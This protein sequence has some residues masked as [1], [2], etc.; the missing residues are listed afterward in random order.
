MEKFLKVGVITSTHG[1]KG[2]V[3]VHPTTDDQKRFRTIEYVY[4]QT[5][6]NR[7]S[8]EVQS[9]KFFKQFSI[10]KFKGIDSINDVEQYQGCELYV[11]REHAVSLKNNEYYI[12]DLIGMEVCLK[13][14][15][16]LGILKDVIKTGAN[17]VYSVDTKNYGEVLI[18]AIKQCVI[19]IEVEIGKMTVCLLPGLINYEGDSVN[20]DMSIL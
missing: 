11:S 16:K 8:L 4:L 2:E 10:L 5:K 20:E 9:I 12:A 14:G 17:D 6:I 7:L 1:I 3:K 13:D 18:P 15:K 19:K